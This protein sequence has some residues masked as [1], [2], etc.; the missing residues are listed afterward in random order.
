MAEFY[1]VLTPVFGSDTKFKPAH[2]KGSASVDYEVGKL[3]TAPPWLADKGYNVT[4]FRT[5]KAAA[6]FARGMYGKRIFRSA[7]M[8]PVTEPLPFAVSALLHKGSIVL[9]KGSG[10][11]EG[12]VM[13]KGVIPLTEVP[14]CEWPR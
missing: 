13:V 3:T 10:W 5:L 6:D 11:P 7:V 2:A 12:T 8:G 9:S 4:V 1:K 14:K